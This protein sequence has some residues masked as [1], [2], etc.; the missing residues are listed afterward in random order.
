MVF[1]S[2]NR[3]IKHDQ[4]TF[5]STGNSPP[6]KKLYSLSQGLIWNFKKTKMSKTY[7]NYIM[8]VS[9][10]IFDLYVFTRIRAISNSLVTTVSYNPL[11][12]HRNPISYRR[13]KLKITNKICLPEFLSNLAGKD[14]QTPTNLWRGYFLKLKMYFYYCT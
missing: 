4:H 10:V 2:C 12:I 14:Q 8:S 7:D 11:F 3:L 13:F 1:H 5:D 6:P 9:H